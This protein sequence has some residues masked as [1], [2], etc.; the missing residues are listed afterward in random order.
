MTETASPRSEANRGLM[1]WSGREF[2]A[3]SF[4]PGPSRRREGGIGRGGGTKATRSPPHA[5]QPCRMRHSAELHFPNSGDNS[6]APLE[7]SDLPLRPRAAELT[8]TSSFSSGAHRP[9]RYFRSP[10]G[11]G[12]P[13]RGVAMVT[14]SLIGR[15]GCGSC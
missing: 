7:P 1:Q 12:G 14:R 9:L 6:T 8:Y 2:P 13:N 4:P 11:R 3:T 10:R 5:Q 15:A